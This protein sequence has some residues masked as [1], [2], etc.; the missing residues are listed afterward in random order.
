M[1]RESIRIAN[2]IEEMMRVMTRVE[3]F[4]R[5]NDLSQ[6]VVNDISVALDEILNNVISY[7]YSDTADHVIGVELSFDGAEVTAVVTDDGMPFDPLQIAPPKFESELKA[8]R[9]G[10][11]GVHFVRNLMDQCSYSRLDGRNQLTL[12]KRVV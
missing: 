5:D 11:V 8:R 10:G 7:G 3:T 1:V 12:R 9:V 6:S 4:G 2:K